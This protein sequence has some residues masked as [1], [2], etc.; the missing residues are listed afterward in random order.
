MFRE[1]ACCDAEVVGKSQ[2]RKSMSTT[3]A[4]LSPLAHSVSRITPDGGHFY[5]TDYSVD[6]PDDGPEVVATQY[7]TDATG[8]GLWVWQPTGAEYVDGDGDTVS[9]VYEW[10]LVTGYTQFNLNCSAATRRTRVLAGMGFLP[11]DD[12]RTTRENY[13]RT[14]RIPA[15]LLPSE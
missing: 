2:Q 8:R 4:T 10:H 5:W 13:A 6:L 9:R 11:D 15:D 14:P 3:I 12:G 7:R 1:Q